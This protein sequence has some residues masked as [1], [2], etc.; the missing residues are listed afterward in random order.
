MKARDVGVLREIIDG[1]S[2]SKP[3]VVVDHD[4]PVAMLDGMEMT[5][6]EM[7]LQQFEYDTKCAEV[8]WTCQCS[9]TALALKVLWGS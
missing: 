1:F 9:I 5:K 2:E 7:T 8:H 6:F 4:M 3:V